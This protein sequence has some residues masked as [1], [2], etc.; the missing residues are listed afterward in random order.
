[1]KDH[2][3]HFERLDV[4]TL[5]VQVAR[6]MRSTRWPTNARHLQDQAIRAAD[7]VVL[8]LAEGLSRGGKPGQNH[9]R[10]A[11]GSAGEAYAALHVADFPECAERRRELRRIAAMLHKLR[12]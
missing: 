5:A 7:S 1:M 12:V 8:N 4:Y 6:W 2:E 11:K 3:F 10:I 9:L